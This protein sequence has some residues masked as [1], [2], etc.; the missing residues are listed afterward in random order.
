LIEEIR[1]TQQF[2]V[3][4]GASVGAIADAIGVSKEVLAAKKY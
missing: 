4:L 1:S 2:M 3:G